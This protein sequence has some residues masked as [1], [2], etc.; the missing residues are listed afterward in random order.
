M[1]EKFASVKSI[2]VY[3]S[4]FA[5]IS[6]QVLDKAVGFQNSLKSLSKIRS[7]LVNVFQQKELSINVLEFFIRI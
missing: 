7:F 6:P 2:V 1:F 3:L 5:S 4:T